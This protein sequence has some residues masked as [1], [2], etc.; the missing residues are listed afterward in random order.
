MSTTDTLA[1]R[2]E[3]FDAQA[4]TFFQD[5]L[6]V[7]SQD[8]C[9]HELA[10]DAR[11]SAQRRK[12]RLI[13]QRAT[14]LVAVHKMQEL[15]AVLP[16]IRGTEKA[17]VARYIASAEWKDSRAAVVMKDVDHIASEI[18][19]RRFYQD[20]ADQ[21]L[22]VWGT[23]TEGPAEFPGRTFRYASDGDEGYR[24]TLRY[25]GRLY[26]HARGEK[27]DLEGW[28]PQEDRGLEAA[29][30]EVGAFAI[31]RILESDML[32]SLNV[33]GQRRLSEL[34]AEV[35]AL[36]ALKQVASATLPAVH[37]AFKAMEWGIHQGHDDLGGR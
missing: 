34:W 23:N 3:W 17:E 12:N 25:V 32:S 33:A 35:G 2:P 9:T 4:L 1:L 8:T 6:A 20:R 21:H 5:L 13:A 11:D 24:N 14:E 19:M 36:V 26:L 31:S 30:T 15:R 22:R 16:R 27:V 7:V 37:G 18:T 10:E 28:E 29:L